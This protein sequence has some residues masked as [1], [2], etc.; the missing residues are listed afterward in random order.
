MTEQT[1][2]A[3]NQVVETADAAQAPPRQ[4]VWPTLVERVEKAERDS[5][6]L[7]L[8][9]IVMVPLLAYLFVNQQFPASVVEREPLVAADR[10]QLLD[11]EGN[12]RLF[13]RIYSGVPVMQLMD[14]H[15]KPRMS[16]GLRYDDTPF[17]SLADTGGQTRATLQVGDE[18]KPTLQLF[19]ENGDS[20]FS[21]N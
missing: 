21:V 12:P 2:Q 18:D 8:V 3:T 4:S 11:R 5:R 13:L 17:I 14:Q 19:D 9:L 20:T 10:L 15:G 16:L 7:K 6:R 1:M